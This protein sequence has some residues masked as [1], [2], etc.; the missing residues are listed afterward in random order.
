MNISLVCAYSKWRK[1]VQKH[2]KP[3]CSRR[4]W[5]RGAAAAAAPFTEGSVMPLGLVH[6]WSAGGLCSQLTAAAS[7]RPKHTHLLQVQRSEPHGPNSSSAG[8]GISARICQLLFQVMNHL[9]TLSS[10]TNG[11]G[12]RIAEPQRVSHSTP[13][14][15]SRENLESSS[16]LNVQC[17]TS[18]FHHL[19]RYGH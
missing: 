4:R 17:N 15:T 1:S 18:I 14:Q 3:Y 10:S 5:A 12:P 9:E 19:C 8:D 2:A 11:C 13:A 6:T 16:G 7:L